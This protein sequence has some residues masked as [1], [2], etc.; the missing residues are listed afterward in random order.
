MKIRTSLL[1]AAALVALAAP[2]LAQDTR[3]TDIDL[4]R[5]GVELREV[6]DRPVDE[7]VLDTALVFTNTGRVATRVI[8]K[9]FDDNGEAVGRTALSVPGLGLRFVLASDVANGTDF[10]GS[11]QCSTQGRVLG[12]AF[13]LGAGGL[14]D[15]PAKQ[16]DHEGALRV[17][18][19]VVATR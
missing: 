5:D 8:C 18:F 11:V 12:S 7:D 6:L 2:S 10:L 4:S 14:T 9:A 19:P 13:L 17:R 15:L 16:A 1:G 3:S